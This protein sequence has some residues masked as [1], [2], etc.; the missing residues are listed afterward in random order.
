MVVTEWLTHLTG[1]TAEDDAAIARVGAN[2]LRGR[3]QNAGRSA[4]AELSW[5]LAT[6]SIHAASEGIWAPMLL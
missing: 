1:A 2:N 3:D 4:T 5:I 6:V